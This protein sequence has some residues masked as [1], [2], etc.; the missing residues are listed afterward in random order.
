MQDLLALLA[1]YGSAGDGTP[2]SDLTG[3]GLVNVEDLLGLLAAF[4]LQ[5][6]CGTPLRDS[7]P[8]HAPCSG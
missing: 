1:D 5:T 3:D 8:P 2:S 7:M 4:A 6:D